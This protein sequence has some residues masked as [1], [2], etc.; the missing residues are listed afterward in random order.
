VTVDHTDRQAAA[1][2]APP[3]LPPADP[4]SPP[5]GPGRAPLSPAD[6]NAAFAAGTPRMSRRVMGLGIAALLVLGM[7]GALADHFV[8]TSP[9]STA[10]S[11]RSPTGHSGPV[12][13]THAGTATARSELHAPLAAFMGL[14]SLNNAAAAPFT[15]TD[16]ATGARISLASLTGHVVVLTFA[17]AACN[18]ICPVLSKELAQAA[19]MLGTTPTPVTF[20]TVNTDPLALSPGDAAMLTQGTLGTVPDYRFLTGSVKQLNP[21]WA[22]YGISIT[23]DRATRVVTHN[24]LMY[25]IAP[26][27]K[28]AWA[29]TPFANESTSGTYSLPA[30]EITRFA[31]GIAQYARKLAK[32]P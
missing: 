25:F 20:V 13:P 3:E 27:G 22:S 1:A 18:D 7:G 9:P 12:V 29:A 28:I 26:S 16:A 24:E 17:D 8:T 23:V 10:A 31:T 6:R 19:A 14:S 5:P 32:A 2:A 15:L 21:V 4:A 11:T 30:A